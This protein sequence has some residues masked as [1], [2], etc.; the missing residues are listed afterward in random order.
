MK[1]KSKC[2][3]CNGS[4]K[5]ELSKAEKDN[6]VLFKKRAVKTLYKNGYGVRQI[7]RLLNYKSTR[8]VSVILGLYKYRF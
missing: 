1:L 3:I 8:S 2:P 6:N 5:I 7:M 4:G